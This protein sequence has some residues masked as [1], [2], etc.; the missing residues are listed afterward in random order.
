MYIEQLYTKPLS[1]SAYYIESG[2]EAAVIDPILDVQPYL[3]LAERRN[4]KIRF[5]FATH[6]QSD[7]VSGCLELSRR[8]GAQLVYGPGATADFPLHAAADG[9]EFR[10]GFL[11]FRVL[12]TP[13]HTPESVCYL[14]LDDRNNPHSIF[15]GDTLFV[16]D[17]GRPDLFSESKK[18]T[19]KQAGI[20]Y[21]SLHQKLMPLANYVVVYPGHGAGSPCGKMIGKDRHST[22]G[23][24]RNS[25][26]ALK[27]ATR[28]EFVSQVIENSGEPPAYFKRVGAMNRSIIEPLDKILERN[29]NP[30]SAGQFMAAMLQ[31]GHTVIDTRDAEAFSQAHL[32]GSVFIGREGNFEISAALVLQPD[33]KLLVVCD[34]G[35]EKEVFTRLA[36]TGFVNV[37]GYLDGGLSAWVRT[38]ASV[39]SLENIAAEY[40]AG[41]FRYNTDIIVDVRNP[42][43]WIPGIIAGAKLISLQY[44]DENISNLDRKKNIFVYCS[45]GYRS[46]IAASILKRKGFSR[47]INVKGGM[48]QMK[49]TPIP[50]RQLSRI[51]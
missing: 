50:V 20:L 23:M 37:S 36:I 35:K 29:L 1:A 24:Q 33:D 45:S 31:R 41:R 8:T 43:E 30:L 11:S 47:V 4:T 5:V 27:A 26:Y 28:N 17:V 22:M 15:T 25:N 12:H 51:G 34:P 44:L 9:E 6:F 46:M 16:D 19:I 10:I 40:V 7:H 39:E 18:E 2:K 32:P 21:D 42:S 13:G 49:Q 3:D 38:G 48:Q 14:L